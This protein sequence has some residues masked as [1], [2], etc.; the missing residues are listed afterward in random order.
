MATPGAM[1]MRRF[2]PLA[3]RFGSFAGGTLVLY[4]EVFIAGTS[5]PLLVFLGL[6]LCG[7]PPAMFFDGLRKL[8]EQAKESL[9]DTVGELDDVPT[10]ETKKEPDA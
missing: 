7:I 2:R 6:W 3:I 4:H 8:T 9:V 1:G 5:E 10:A